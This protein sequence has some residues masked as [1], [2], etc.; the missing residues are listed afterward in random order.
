MKNA[1][2]VRYLVSREQQSHGDSD[3]H[4]S[5]LPAVPDTHKRNRIK[6]TGIKGQRQGSLDGEGGPH[7]P[8]GLRQT[9][10]PTPQ[11]TGKACDGPR[12]NHAARTREAASLGAS[13]RRKVLSSNHGV[14]VARWV[15]WVQV[16]GSEALVCIF[17]RNQQP[18]PSEK[19]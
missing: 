10:P 5:S 13:G 8:A 9:F 11:F 3:H 4:M 17:E 2:T 19:S 6:P 14:Q 1:T 16:S 12:L 7:R 15:T 18:G